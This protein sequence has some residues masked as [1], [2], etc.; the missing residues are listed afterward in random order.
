MKNWY[1]VGNIDVRVNGAKVFAFKVRRGVK[2]GDPL[3]GAL[4]ALAV[5]I[6]IRAAQAA[7]A[8]YGGIT[9]YADDMSLILFNLPAQIKVLVRVVAILASAAALHLN[10]KKKQVSCR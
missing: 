3:S 9:A 8:P 6:F 2:Q 7:L 10:F 1:E 5:D 4:F